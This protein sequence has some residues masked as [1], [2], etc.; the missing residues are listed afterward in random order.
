MPPCLGVEIIAG[1]QQETA[2]HLNRIGQDL[3]MFFNHKIAN[4]HY[5]K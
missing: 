5:R 3:I 2:A 4:F 1:L